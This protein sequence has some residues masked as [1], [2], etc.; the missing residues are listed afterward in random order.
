M[1]DIIQEKINK[2]Y[3]KENLLVLGYKKELRLKCLDCGVHYV[4]KNIDNALAK[5]KKVICRNCAK[6]RKKLNAA[7]T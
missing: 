2:K 3:P 5:H 1:L 4:F 6:R 7:T